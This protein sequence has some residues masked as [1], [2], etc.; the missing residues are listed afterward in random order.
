[1]IDKNELKLS[2]LNFLLNPNN[3]VYV[4]FHVTAGNYRGKENDVIMFECE[5]SYTTKQ[6][7]TNIDKR[8]LNVSL[9]GEM[10]RGEEEGR[11]DSQRDIDRKD[12]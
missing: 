9:A 5:I 3:Y 12:E 2:P 8:F 7:R 1:M 11:G 6:G 4:P 10:K